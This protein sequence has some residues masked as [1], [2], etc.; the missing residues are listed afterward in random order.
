MS[1][2]TPARRS[3]AP[4]PGSCAVGACSD[5]MACFGGGEGP[6]SPCIKVCELD[7][8]TGWCVGCGRTAAEIGDWPQMTSLDKRDLLIQLPVRLNRLGAEGKRKEA[9]QP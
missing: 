6:P 9:A 5:C 2:R 7:P 3:V 1:R 8:V 4:Y